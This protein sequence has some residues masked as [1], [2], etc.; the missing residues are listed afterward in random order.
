MVRVHV[1]DDDPLDWRVELRKHR[2]PPF[3]RIVGAETRVDEDPAAA[4]G[5]KEVAMDVVDAERQ[6]EREAADPFLDLDHA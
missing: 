6:R 4:R 1:R 3:G 5:T 2:S